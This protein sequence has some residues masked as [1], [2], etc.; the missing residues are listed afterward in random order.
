MRADADEA[1]RK[2][3]AAGL[4]AP[5]AQL[6]QGVARVLCGDLDGGEAFLAD[7]ISLG[8][9]GAPETLAVALV[10]RSLVAA[11]R[12]QWDQAEAFASRARSVM[13]RAGLEESFVTPM[14]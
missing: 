5:A 10:Q 4:V 8:D 9:V 6:M 1:A 14:V 3:A 11:G 13:R 7:A 2:F 12:S